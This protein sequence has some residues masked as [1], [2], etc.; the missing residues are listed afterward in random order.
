MRH[1][2]HDLPW[3]RRLLDRIDHVL[4]VALFN[5]F[6]LPKQSGFRHSFQF[7]GESVDR[8]YSVLVFPEGEVTKTG[9]MVSFRA[10]IGVLAT[11]LNIPVVPM[12]IDG[13]FEVKQ[14]GRRMAAPGT[15]QVSIGAPV[16]FPSDID[17]DRIARELQSAV[18]SLRALR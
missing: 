15:V 8:G 3:W 17:P 12:R 6:P 13:L 9:E 5:V 4:L 16:R 11:K 10:G 14:A 18:A 1:P 7:A 2:R